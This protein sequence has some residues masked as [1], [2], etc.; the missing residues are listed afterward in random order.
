[1]P[2]LEEGVAAGPGLLSQQCHASAATV[3]QAQPQQ[4]E[5]LERP[6]EVLGK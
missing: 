5:Q 6:A 1:M 3:L 4:M 2:P